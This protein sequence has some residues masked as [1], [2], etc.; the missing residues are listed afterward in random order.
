MTLQQTIAITRFMNDYDIQSID[1]T[2][3]FGRVK[4]D[5]VLVTISGHARLRAVIWHDG[6][7]EW[8]LGDKRV[9]EEMVR[10]YFV[11]W[12]FMKKA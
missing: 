12:A 1:E 2:M 11:T 8:Y 4:Q 3:T 7:C 5:N 10:D 9:S 6:V